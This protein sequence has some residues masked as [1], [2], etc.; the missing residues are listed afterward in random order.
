[1]KAVVI[2]VLAVYVLGAVLF[3]GPFTLP[4]LMVGLMAVLT[5]QGEVLVKTMREVRD[6]LRRHSNATVDCPKC[7][8]RI[9]LTDGRGTCGACGQ[10][11]KA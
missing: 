9:V 1:M 3:G 4:L 11:V 2:G 7:K 6:E 5:A 10:S 8:W